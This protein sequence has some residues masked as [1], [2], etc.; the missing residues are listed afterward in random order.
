M[1]MPLFLLI[2]LQDI[3]K[4]LICVGVISVSRL[5]SVEILDRVVKLSRASMGR[6][7]NGAFIV[8]EGAQE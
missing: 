7:L 4:L 6:P 2:R 1:G 8:V 5:Y 3:Q